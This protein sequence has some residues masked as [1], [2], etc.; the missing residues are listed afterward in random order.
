M[1]ILVLADIESKYLWDHFKK[2]Y[3]ED[4]DLIISCGDLKAS[5]L[6]FLATFT[7]APVLYVHGNH[8]GGYNRKPP[9]GCVCIDDKVIVYKGI[10]IAGLGG[11]IWYNNGPHQYTQ[12]QMKQRVRKLWKDLL[13]RKGIDILVT[14]SPAKGINDGEDHAHEGFE[15]FTT[16]LDK[17]KPKYFL[18]GHV[19][20]TYGRKYKRVDQY[21]D[22]TVINGFERYIVEIEDVSEEEIKKAPWLKESKLY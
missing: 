6:S 13:L 2:E 10:R 20:T 12:K 15:A 9:E 14:H 11:S 5:Y 16:L 18:H 3:L 7:S 19:H 8:D 4:I 17:Y 22:T 21:G 1:K